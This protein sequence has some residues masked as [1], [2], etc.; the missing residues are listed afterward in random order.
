[1]EDSRHRVVGLAFNTLS[2]RP[3]V[4][5]SLTLE[6]LW[7]FTN[8]G[9]DKLRRGVVHRQSLSPV[10]SR[11]KPVFPYEK[12]RSGD[13]FRLFLIVRLAGKSFANVLSAAFLGFAA[14]DQRRF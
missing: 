14:R 8:E 1:M 3:F 4:S 2:L 6:F 13:I 9:F 11:F 7:C 12:L 5:L 10:A